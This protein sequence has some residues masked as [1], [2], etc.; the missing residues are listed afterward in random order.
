MRNLLIFF[1]K[2]VSGIREEIFTDPSFP[3]H[4]SQS[5]SSRAGLSPHLTAASGGGRY[6]GPQFPQTNNNQLKENY[7]RV[8]NF[9]IHPPALSPAELFP[10]YLVTTN[11]KAIQL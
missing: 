9:L 5:A 6:H 8:M 4:C 1:L 10:G 2:I 11:K 3:R 7:R